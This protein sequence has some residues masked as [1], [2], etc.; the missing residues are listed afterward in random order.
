MLYMGFIIKYTA[1]RGT[2]ANSSWQTL[3][4]LLELQKLKL[5]RNSKF[6]NFINPH[7][8]PSKDIKNLKKFPLLQL[9]FITRND[10]VIMY[11]EYLTRKVNNHGLFHSFC[12]ALLMITHNDVQPKHEDRNCLWEEDLI[13]C[14]PLHLKSE[15]FT[16]VKGSDY[17]LHTRKFQLK[18]KEN[19]LILNYLID[20]KYYHFSFNCKWLRLVDE[21]GK[22]CLGEDLTDPLPQWIRARTW[23]IIISIYLFCARIIFMTTV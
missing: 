2:V 11:S 18:K 12:I 21:Y 15:Y 1:R 17:S 14:F 19:S 23:P 4:D 16:I 9:V 20:Y 10:F 8:I 7:D 22:K 3:T 5:K 6:K 13:K